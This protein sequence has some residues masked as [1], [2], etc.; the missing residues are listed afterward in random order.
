MSTGN[1]AGIWDGLDA[2]LEAMRAGWGIPGFGI[3]I[4][5]DGKPAVQKGFGLAD[6]ANGIPVDTDTVFAIGSCSKAFTA[7]AAAMLVDRGLLDWDRPIQSYIPWFDLKDGYAGRHATTRDLLCHRTGLPRHDYGWY[8]SPASR[9]EMVERL[10]HFEPNKSFRST[11]QY[12][13]MM[14]AVVGYLIEVISGQTWEDF[15]QA[16]IFDPLGMDCSSFRVGQPVPRGRY[17]KPYANAGGPVELPYYDF[18]KGQGESVI[19]PAGSINAPIGDMAKWL[20]FQ[21][22]NGCCEGGRLISP[23]VFREMHKPQ[24]LQSVPLPWSEVSLP[25]Y[26]FGWTVAGLR[27]HTIVYH[28]GNIDG[29]SALVGQLPSEGLGL[30]VLTNLNFNRFSEAVMYQVFDRALGVPE[31]DWD[32]RLHTLF[33][34]NNELSRKKRALVQREHTAPSHPLSDYAGV[35]S[36]P[37]YGEVTVS[38][39]EN[40]LAFSFHQCC[41][42]LEHFHFDTFMAKESPI[43]APFTFSTDKRGDVCSFTVP[44]GEEDGMADILFQRIDAPAKGAD[45]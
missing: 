34:D 41:G 22:G 43:N 27:G 20:A 31:V 13:N 37:G 30:V 14:Y 24:M 23:E 11:W 19:G 6:V 1:D 2:S 5:K 16:Q 36:N 21:L 4:I 44:L 26:G 18:Y 45:A 42:R 35:F 25:S 15:V 28:T 7:A 8:F 9:R 3:A 29:F 40:G 17:A 33:H 38:A 39:G 12:Q 32:A 10:R